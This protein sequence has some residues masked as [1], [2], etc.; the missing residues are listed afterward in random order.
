LKSKAFGFSFDTTDVADQYTACLN[1]MDKYYV[2]LM[3]GALDVESTI[4]Q[5]NSEFENAGL[6][7]IIEAKQKQLDEYLAADK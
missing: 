5:A 3:C 7:D 1:I 2:A 4:A 6:K